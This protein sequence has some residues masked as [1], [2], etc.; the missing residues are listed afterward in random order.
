MLKERG[1]SSEDKEIFL[2]HLCDVE[3]PKNISIK[4]PDFLNH[5]CDVEETLHTA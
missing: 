1:Y 5:L 2:N 4:N 3:A